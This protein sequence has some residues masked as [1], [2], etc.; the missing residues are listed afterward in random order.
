MSDARRELLLGGLSSLV[1]G[2]RPV[3][4]SVVEL[5]KLKRQDSAASFN[6]S[7]VINAEEI[8]QRYKRLQPLNALDDEKDYKT[9]AHTLS[10]DKLASI[11]KT[12][13]SSQDN[14]RCKVGP[15]GIKED[16]ARIYFSVHGKNQITPQP[17]R[18]IWFKLF[19]LTFCGIFNLLLWGCVVAEVALIVIFADRSVKD[20]EIGGEGQMMIR[21][22]SA[23][24]LDERRDEVKGEDD[25]DYVTPCILSGVIVMAA[26]LQWYSELKAEAQ[27]DAMQKMQSVKP[28]P[29]VRIDS[30]GR[31]VDFEQDSKNLVPGDIIFLEAGDKVPAD[32]RIVYCTDGME[33]DNAP[34]N[35]ES[36]PDPRTA[37][38][39]KDSV[40]PMDAHN[41][42]YF[43]TP[44]L[45]G[46]ATCVVHA[47][48][49]S[50]FLGKIARSVRSSRV[51]STLEIQI[52]HFIHII[53]VVAIIVG[54]MSLASNILSPV[55]RSPSDILQNSAA[56]LFAQVPEGLLPTVTISLMIASDQMAKRNV[57][58]RKIDAIETLG[59]VSVFCSDKTGTLTTGEMATQDIVVPAGSNVG[60]D[61]LEVVNREHGSGKFNKVG[62][63][64]AR[65]HL[66][67][68]AGLLNNGAELKKDEDGE[69]KWCGSPTEVA[70]LQGCCELVGGNKEMNK[71][72]AQPDNQKVFE[73]PF[74]SENKW[75][76]TIH[77]QQGGNKYTM[78][79]KGAPERVLKF[80]SLS[81]DQTALAKVEEKLQDLMGQG[82]RVLCIAKRELSGADLPKVK[83]G[84]SVKFEG[85]CK[86]DVNFTMNNF[87][88]VGLYGIEDP[89]KKGVAEAVLAARSAGVKVVMVTGDHPDTAR[90]IASRINILNNDD[91]V[92]G[93]SAEQVS[94]RAAEFMV[95]TGAMLDDKVP[96]GDN[97][98][99]DDDPQV[100]NWWKKA[101]QHARVFARVS[102]IHKQVIVYA[103]QKFGYGG[104]GDVVAMTGDGV[105]DAPALKAAQVGV[106]MGIRGTDVA[107]D[108]ADIVLNDDN[109]A[110]CIVGIEQGRLSSDNLQK[111]IMYTLCS[112]VPQVAP[113]FAELFGVPQAL[114]VAQILLIDIGTDIWT[115]IAY[116]VQLPESKLMERL[117]R[118]PIAEKMV[119][120][121]VLLYSY[122]YIGPLQMTFCWVM[123]FWA[124]PG[125]YDLYA[126]GKSPNEYNASDEYTDKQGMTVY[127]WT[128]VLG[129]I[130]AAIS[131]TTKLESV[132][133]SY[134]LSNGTLNMMFVGEIAVG[135]AA[136]YVGPMQNLFNTASLPRSAVLLPI[137]AFVGICFIEEIRKCIGRSFD[138]T[139]S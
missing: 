120:W 64:K 105:N 134:G 8:R 54:L 73:I 49:D 115:A 23:A 121:K 26:L 51:K 37:K 108:A 110:S 74:N 44:V 133:C 35:G 20:Q 87:E 136:I 89:P 103:Y 118:H 127:Y 41:L 75:M 84:D 91:I 31:R 123:F 18:N 138:E 46:N 59:C 98:S 28:V 93:E 100:I 32:V 131:T 99:D 60:A 33:V 7:I 4:G 27:M 72:K 11:F 12:K 113:T 128:L 78:F 137:I 68:I 9:L 15:C 56:A 80:C 94:F 111:S 34:L 66:V 125:L 97:F 2:P 104:L 122:G 40:P 42:A 85:S 101:V 58:V 76:V 30:N 116:A 29:T 67:G 102:P 139:T 47:T 10:N 17:R 83:P 22:Q 95:I 48:G 96:K 119:N 45:K 14:G 124:S 77:G 36:V 109:F 1:P 25:S 86:D 57:I 62:S 69:E 135:I 129:Q 39:E 6:S 50:T 107:K 65:L 132:F 117:P 43:G 114:T 52:E 79:M 92:T 3:A 21:A 126:S 106:A 63:E 82:R 130:A 24:S 19:E 61:G 5:S 53:A 13:I 16:Q 38:V 90:A 71:L 112:K 55:D 81:T 88:F 70:I